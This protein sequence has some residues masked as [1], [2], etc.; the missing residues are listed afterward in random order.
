M[1]TVD[2]SNK[3]A[4]FGQGNTKAGCEA[5]SKP[6]DAPLKVGTSEDEG[7]DEIERN[8]RRIAAVASF[9]ELTEGYYIHNKTKKKKKWIRMDKKRPTYYYKNIGH[10]YSFY[11]RRR[12][13]LSG[14]KSDP[15]IF[16]CFRKKQHPLTVPAEYR[17]MT[18][19]QLRAVRANADRRCIEEGWTNYKGERLTPDQVSLYDINKYVILPFTI[20]TKLSFVSALPSTAGPQPP[21]WFVSH[22]WGEPIHQFIPCIEQLVADFKYNS[23]AEHGMRGGGMNDDTPIWVCAYAN[24]QWKLSDAIT[25]DP[26][27]SSFYRAMKAAQGRT[28]TIIDS[29]GIVFTRIWCIFELHLTLTDTQEEKDDD[30]SEVGVWASYTAKNHI[31]EHQGKRQNRE[32]VGIISGGSTADDGFTHDNGLRYNISNRESHF[33]IEVLSNSLKIQVEQAQA[34]IE[35]DRTHILNSISGEM[36][37]LD[38]KPPITHRNYTSLNDAISGRFAS[39]CGVL[40]AALKNGPE[41]WEAVLAAMSR[42][43]TTRYIG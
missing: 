17:G 29:K 30:T 38:I 21:R 42:S 15:T 36:E 1:T 16:K 20:K 2:A 5:V 4:V 25:N 10:H 37:N 32:A 14:K 9:R 43:F 27:K 11:D 24:N 40:Q 3:T 12:V 18:L 28:V 23:R 41:L 8:A 33:P 6:D 39:S 19:R 7:K 13:Y 31:S 35:N 26:K 34:S 22:W